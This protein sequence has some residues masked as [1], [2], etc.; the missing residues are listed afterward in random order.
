MN[1]GGCIVSKNIYDHIARIKWCF[2]E[3][4]VNSVDNGWR[5][6]SEIDTDDFLS[7]VENMCVCSFETI[8]EIEPAVLGIYSLPVGTELIL[9]YDGKKR[10]FTDGNTGQVVEI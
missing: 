8:V 2:R 3:Q 5:F 1:M 6:L 7:H 10:F 9:N 4:S